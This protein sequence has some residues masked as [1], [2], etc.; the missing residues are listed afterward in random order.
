MP[1]TRCVR[2][3]SGASLRF[4]PRR[5]SSAAPSVIAASVSRAFPA[6][7]ESEMCGNCARKSRKASGTRAFIACGVVAM[8]SFPY[9]SICISLKRSGM[10]SALRRRSDA[11][12][13]NALPSGVS[14]I[15]RPFRSNRRTSYS[16]SSAAI[17]WLTEGCDRNSRSAARRNDPSSTM[18]RNTRSR[19]R[20]TKPP[21]ASRYKQM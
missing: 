13:C 14:A 21:P 5:A 4:L 20:F 15:V 11:R 17:F 9:L 10:S 2:R 18:V 19:S 7:S 8:A 16:L 3:D 6:A 12:T 1:R